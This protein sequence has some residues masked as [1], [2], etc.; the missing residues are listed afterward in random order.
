MSTNALQ[1]GPP[2]PVKLGDRLSM[3]VIRACDRGD[4]EGL[5]MAL[6]EGLDPD[7]PDYWP[8]IARKTAEMALE[9]RRASIA[10]ISDHEAFVRHTPDGSLHRV[11]R[12]VTLSLADKT[13]W[14]LVK[15]APYLNGERFRGDARGRRDIEWREAPVGDPDTGTVTY[16]GFLAMNAVV[17]AAVGQPPSVMVDGVEH[18][19]PYVERWEDKDGRKRD[20]VRIVISI[21]VVGPA[22]ET[23]NPTVVNY[24]LDYDPTKDLASMLDQ[25]A[26]TADTQDDC[27]L[28]PEDLAKQELKGDKRGWAFLP[29]MGGI[30]Y[31]HNLRNSAVR[32]C[33]GKYVELQGNALKKAQTVARRNAMKSH[34]AL[35]TQYVRMDPKTKTAR[36]AITGW[37]GDARA[38]HRWTDIQTRLS[39]GLDLPEAEEIE[40]IRTAEVYDPERHGDTGDS[41]DVST[42]LEEPLDPHDQER[43]DLIAEIDGLLTI[44]SPSQV[45]ELGYDPGTNTTEQL[46]AIRNQIGAIVDRKNS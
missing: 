28:V 1:K 22:P 43:N 15:R 23:G 19:N 3:A 21:I 40:I 44:L 31:I 42:R 35:G 37:A 41:E 20:I 6:G 38:M 17:G 26:S 30:G 29:I 14:Q 9:I 5:L 8:T 45:Q 16:P 11:V 18:T 25:V 24:T 39:Q 2:K 7:S 46:L 33:Y 10:V 27:Y 4:Q 34:P 13:L 32:D 12:P 36:L